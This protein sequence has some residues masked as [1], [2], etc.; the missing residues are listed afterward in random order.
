M[1]DAFFVNYRITQICSGF[2]GPGRKSHGVTYG[3]VKAGFANFFAAEKE[4]FPRGSGC[5]T[6]FE[7]SPLRES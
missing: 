4:K 7:K 5:H 3:V 1:E 6:I 2:D